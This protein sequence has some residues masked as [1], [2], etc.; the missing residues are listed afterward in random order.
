MNGKKKVSRP[1]ASSSIPKHAGSKMKTQ[2]GN[3]LPVNWVRKARSY[4]FREEVSKPLPNR[5]Y[6]TKYGPGYVMQISLKTCF[7][8]FRVAEPEVKIGFTTFTTLRPRN[9]RLV[10]KNQWIYCVCTVCQNIRYKLS[11]L[12]AT[13]SRDGKRDVRLNGFD[14]VLQTV[15]CKKSDNE[16]YHKMECIKRSCEACKDQGEKIKEHYEPLSRKEMNL[17]WNHWERVTEKDG[18]KRKRLVVKAG[19]REEMIAEF[20]KDIEQPVK[21][22]SFALHN[23]SE[24][25]QTKQYLHI[26]ENLPQKTALMVLDFGRNSY[27]TPGRS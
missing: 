17:Q 1:K 15:L 13:A 18:E 20:G 8:M 16:R 6:T 27:K 7:R 14:D 10:G 2:H 3:R 25:W 5:R 26:K 23:F 19:S 21:G 24:S 12:N 4:F 11:S 9:V 22:K